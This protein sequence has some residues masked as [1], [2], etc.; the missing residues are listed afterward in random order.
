MEINVEVLKTVHLE[1][2]P[3]L[4]AQ[5]QSELA[6]AVGVALR[7][8]LDLLE[9]ALTPSLRRFVR[10]AEITLSKVVALDWSIIK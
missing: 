9:I 4:T 2:V 1:N 7:L 10:E 5:Q 8:D 6:S 3:A